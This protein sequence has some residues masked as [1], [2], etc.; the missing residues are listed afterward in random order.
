MARWL[1]IV[2]PLFVTSL[3]A[4][5]GSG[6]ALAL[7]H[8]AVIACTVGFRAS[9]QP[10]SASQAMQCPSYGVASGILVVVA[11]VAGT[12]LV[13]LILR[14]S[15][16][17]PA[18][19]VG[20]GGVASGTTSAD[21]SP[22]N[23]RFSRRAPWPVSRW[24]CL[25]VA[26]FFA[27]SFFAESWQYLQLIH[28]S[29]DLSINQQIL[30]S[31]VLGG[32]PY[33][34]Y[35]SFT[36]G[37]LGDCTFL[38]EHQ[39]FLAFP[40]AL[41]YGIA[42]TPFTLF[43]IQSLAIGL[44]A[45]PLYA[46]AVDVIGSRRLSLVV[47][48]TYLAWLP[49]FIAAS[50]DTF[51]WEAFLPVEMLT[52]FLFWNRQRYLYAIPVVLLAFCTLE[53]ST[54]LA[55][56][57]GFF[58]LWPWIVRAVH[59]LGHSALWV[60]GETK[61][62]FSWARPWGRWVWK[63]FHVPEVYA[64]LSLMAGSLAAYLLLRLFG[65]AIGAVFGIPP[66]PAAFAAHAAF[67]NR[68]FALGLSDLTYQWTAKLWFWVVIYLTLGLIPLLAP[69]AII[70]IL[71][72]LAFTF[73]NMD[74]GFWGFSGIYQ[75]VPAAALMIGFVFG[76][77]Q[78]YQWTLARAKAPSGDSRTAEG[79]PTS[80]EDAG[81]PAR[82]SRFRPW[83]VDG[84]RRSNSST[85]ARI[86][87]VGLIV[88]VAGNLFLS[89][90]NPLAADVV[91]NLGAP[92]PSPYGVDWSPPQSEQALE[93]LISVIPKDAIVTAPPL[94]FTLVADDPYAYPM[95]PA[96]GFHYPLLPGNISNRVQYVLL[97][98]T[99][100]VGR[101]TTALLAVLYDRSV[102]GVRACVA[103]S[104]FGGVE[105]F[106]RDYSGAAETFGPAG[107]LCPNYFAGGSGLTPG[108]NSTV[109]SNSSSPSGQVVRSTPCNG[110]DTLVSTGPGISL[111]SGQYGLRVV[112]NVYNATGTTC[113]RNRVP[114]SHVLFTLNVTG[115][116]ASGENQI[117]RHV[118]NV[119][120]IENTVCYQS[121]SCTGWMYWN[122]TVDLSTP[123]TDVSMLTNVLLAQYTAQVAYVVMIPEQS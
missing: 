35:S 103:N 1:R 54:V 14:L 22:N 94:V 25:L 10:L 88:L 47:V 29:D 44:A 26:L 28:F 13:W 59:L 78:L 76:L 108:P 8:G 112:F 19:S 30:A 60:E 3:L 62:A 107:V 58:F 2:S 74:S 102:F 90:L 39:A 75:F 77:N 123:M 23:P 119:S 33:P 97:P 65:T 95:E 61:G 46:L 101:M 110:D 42:P 89:P 4:F 113:L 21:S 38:Q 73:F 93:R 80:A 32:K 34:L 66:L 50:R 85:G 96:A 105:L 52:L 67:L 117:F 100:P 116:N 111:P 83:T 114:A 118:Y 63:S 99:T 72:W 109:A 45:L 71:P 15:N 120:A 37:I 51:H 84:V 70:L 16:A 17:G 20:T 106:Q 87:F 115:Q 79:P 36:C 57:V 40:V 91:P 56:A 9:G 18:P 64:S 68:S 11:L 81:T 55:F 31:T 49:L 121:P 122:S 41:T 12:V 92:F 24:V 5:V 48:V 82:R 53:V 27:V 43:A 86:L 7:L 69:R 104:T 98:Y 6:I